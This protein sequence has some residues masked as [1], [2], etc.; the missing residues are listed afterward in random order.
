M[1]NKDSGKVNALILEQFSNAFESI[2]CKL[3]GKEIVCK[4][5]QSLKAVIPIFVV[6]A[7]KATCPKLVHPLNIY[8]STI[9][10]DPGTE[11]VCSPIHPPKTDMPNVVTDVGIEVMVI[12]VHPLNA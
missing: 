7:C 8:A 9:D 10:I 11:N 4:L 1:V 12:F 6:P 3:L 2:I 5:V